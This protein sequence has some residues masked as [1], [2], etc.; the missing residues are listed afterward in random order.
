MNNLNITKKHSSSNWWKQQRHT[1]QLWND[2]SK[3]NWR[4]EGVRIWTKRSRPWW[5]HLLKQ[6]NWANGS[7]PTP[8]RLGRN[9]HK[10]KLFPWN[11]VDS[12]MAEEECW[13]TGRGTRIYLYCLYWLFGKLFSLDGY[14]AQPRYGREGL[15]PC[16]KQCALPSLRNGWV[17]T[18]L[19]PAAQSWNNNT[20]TL[21][22]VRL[23][24]NMKG[25]H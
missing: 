20:K 17:A 22:F 6:F 4:V 18:C 2:L 25:Q 12:G 23:F 1:S 21:I 16:T 8:V 13:A 15:G 19:F 7:S 9:Q 10:S 11:E 5:V 3:S 14:L 24:C